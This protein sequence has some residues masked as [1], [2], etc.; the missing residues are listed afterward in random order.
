MSD[1]TIK[2]EPVGT[3]HIELVGKEYDIKPPKAALAMRIAFEAKIY[4][5]DPA[6]LG[7]V[8]NAW[9]DRAFMDKA[10]KIRK[11]LDDEDD[12]LDIVHIMALMEAVIEKQTD[13]N[14][15]S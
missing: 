14:P 3:I 15:T 2:A 7:E 12:L 5:D 11:R 1:I 8:I 13:P 10:E 4:Q 6:K 9:I